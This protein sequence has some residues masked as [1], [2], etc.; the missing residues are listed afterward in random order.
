LKVGIGGGVYTGLVNTECGV[1]GV[2]T[3]AIGVPAI[4]FDGVATGTGEGTA[5]VETAAGF[6]G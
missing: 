2:A 4:V 1:I 6:A 3:A 5:G